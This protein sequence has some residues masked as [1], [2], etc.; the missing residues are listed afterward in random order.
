MVFRVPLK[1]RFSDIDHAGIVYYP[2]FFEYVNTAIEEFF[3][4]NIGIDY[5]T[6]V[7]EYRIGLP[8]VHLETDF[9][10]P[11]R[12]GEAFE[13]E[14]AVESVGKTSITFIYA[15]YTAKDREMAIRGK[16][17]MACMDL[18]TFKKKKIPDWLRLKLTSCQ[19]QP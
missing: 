8:T 5:P 14:I 15:I 18:N 2:N 11:L 17:V 6:M 16:K 7:L 12:F 13:V 4:R 1:V 3:S 9:K 19:E 10:R